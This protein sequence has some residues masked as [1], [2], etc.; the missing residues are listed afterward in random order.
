[1]YTF[2]HLSSASFELFHNTFPIITLY[3]ALQETEFSQIH[4]LYTNVTKSE[5]NLTKTQ[6]TNTFKRTECNAF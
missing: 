5:A 1:M 3:K 2:V 6:A 4:L